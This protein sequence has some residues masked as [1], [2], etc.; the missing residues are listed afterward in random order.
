MAATGYVG[1]ET[2][3]G[4]G[5]TLKRTFIEFKEDSLSDWAAGLTY[6]GVLSLF[7]ALLALVS[8]FGL[9]GNPQTVTRTLLDIVGQLGSQSAVQTLRGPITSITA[10]SSAATV[11]FVLGILAA[12]FSA[13]KYV[14]GFMRA[15]NVIY[16][17]H[18]G[19]SILKLRPLQ[20][21]VTLLMILLVVAATIA[22]VVTGPVA[23]AIGSAIGVGSTAV[24]VWNIAKWPVLVLFVALALAVLYYASPNAKPSGFKSILPGALV[25]V[26]VWILVSVAFALYLAF[27]GVKGTY[28]SFGGV[29]VFLI[30]L[31]LTNIAVLF[32]AE[33]N[34][35]RERD[36]QMGARAPGATRDLQLDE[37]DEPE[38]PHTT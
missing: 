7:P 2:K 23:R 32:G 10:N 35:E 31:W 33:F 14:G 25:A 36:R 30:W 16:E 26:V 21:L 28:G 15:S 29:I 37:R 17:V 5:Q 12:L 6:Y 34:A 19:R 9:V 20:M 18:E 24:T 38:R 1:Y 4:F 27:F 22:L 3:T 13:S 8:I 11:S